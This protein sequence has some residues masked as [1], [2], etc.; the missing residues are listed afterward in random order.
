MSK[1]GPESADVSNDWIQTF[2]G[3]HCLVTGGAGV[4]GR[5]LVE[6]LLEAGA[7]VTVIDRAQ[8][9]SHWLNLRARLNYIQMCLSEAGSPEMHWP[10]SADGASYV[11][12]LAAVFQRTE[13]AADYFH[14]NFLNN[15]EGSY[16]LLSQLHDEPDL[17]A[18]VYASSYLCYDEAQYLTDA[19][20][21]EP[22]TLR[23]DAP[24]R[25]RNLTGIAK[26]YHE[27]ELEHLQKHQP[28]VRWISARICRVYG[29]GSKDVLSRWIRAG[30]AGETITAY[31]LESFFDY[32]YADDVAEGLLRMA[33]H[34]K[35][36]GLYNLGSGKSRR[37]GD[38]L[39][40]LRRAIPELVVNKQ[41][42]PEGFRY[43]ASQVD[44]TKTFAALPGFRPRPIEDGLAAVVAHE[45]ECSFS[46]SGDQVLDL[47]PAAMPPCR[48]LLTS[49][50]AKLPLR[51]LLRDSMERAGLPPELFCAD[52][53]PGSQMMRYLASER[54]PSTGQVDGSFVMPPLHELTPEAF[55]EHCR[56]RE[57]T[58]VVPSRDGELLFMA[59]LA[60]AKPK[61]IHFF[62][63]KP[64]AIE[65]CLDKLGFARYGL[66][67]KLQVIPA[68]TK[69]DDIDAERYVVKERR[70]AGSRKIGLNLRCDEARA[71]AESLNEPIFQPFVTGREFS[72]DSYLRPGR[73]PVGTIL[74]WRDRVV[75]GESHVT[76]A[77]RDAAIEAQ[78][79]ELLQAYEVTHHSV[80][81][82]IVD[83]EGQVHFVEVNCR[84][85]GASRLGDTLGLSSVQRW[86]LETLFPD[87]QEPPFPS[88]DCYE[89][90]RL[91]RFPTQVIV[92]S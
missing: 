51:N 18:Y 88:M 36:N 49:A 42:P 74:R 79:L 33:A 14:D 55:L 87:A 48:M 30:L 69:I 76:T 17:K 8:R 16:S 58:H 9:P 1:D 52:S 73:E 91:L 20:P 61:G 5:V 78:V 41:A 7:R 62:V 50:G 21:K 68:S 43:E 24:L 35:V 57:I 6:R 86:L 80:T 77:F 70:G 34:P 64:E 23:E 82:G 84:L 71:W 22:V 25:P 40:F 2:A 60:E 46:A 26:L 89:G 66:Q 37:V 11:F 53:D 38:A 56:S 59:R 27:T 65:R 44:M 90:W 3:E 29:R 75:G 81:Q 28:E 54:G 4:I 39:D 83:P 32:I 85:G 47:D 31:G 67:S 19:P 63:T 45:R 92:P 15:V 13:E 72:A 10:G 12:H